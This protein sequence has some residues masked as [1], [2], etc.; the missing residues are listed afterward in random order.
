MYIS[1][2]SIRSSFS[3]KG[4]P[5]CLRLNILAM[6]MCLSSAPFRVMFNLRNLR[7]NKFTYT[8][9][10]TIPTCTLIPLFSR[11]FIF[12][13]HSIS[14]FLNWS[15]SRFSYILEKKYFYWIHIKLFSNTV[16]IIIAIHSLYPVIRK[17]NH[18]SIIT[19]EI[20]S[21][22]SRIP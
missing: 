1:L 15:Y 4:F 20:F 2:K 12:C 11:M 8:M 14:I 18:L 19:Y 13:W 6:Y 5:Y 3:L 16:E 21:N 9:I 17:K 22:I 10:T 7:F